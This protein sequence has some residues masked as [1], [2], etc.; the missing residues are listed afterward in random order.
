MFPAKLILTVLAFTA[1]SSAAPPPAVKPTPLEPLT[2]EVCLDS[3]A[4]GP[5]NN[6]FDISFDTDNCVPLLG[7][8]GFLNKQ[9]SWVQ[10]PN[11]FICTLFRDSGCIGEG[12][13]ENMVLQSG[14]WDLTNVPGHAGSISFNDLTS[15]FSCSPL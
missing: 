4:S 15:S 3:D 10:V 9:L 13:N 8:L 6:C 5:P 1:V 11:G 14:T 12:I 2:I 7:N